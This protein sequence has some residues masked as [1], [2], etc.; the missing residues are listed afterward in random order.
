MGRQVKALY[1]WVVT[2]AD[3]DEGVLRRSTPIGTQPL[4]ADDVSRALLMADEARRSA[5]AM[6]LPCA[7]R[8]FVRVDGWGD[9]PAEA[10]NN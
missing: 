9:E 10:G 2:D 5:A 1:A 6:G 7:I 4:I 8:K 3:G